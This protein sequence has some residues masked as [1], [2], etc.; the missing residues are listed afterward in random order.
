MS[1]LHMNIG[2][3]SALG[4]WGQLPA[5]AWALP[6][7]PGPHG[8]PC[9]A[10]HRE[11]PLSAKRQWRRHPPP[12]R[13][14]PPRCQSSRQA[15]QPGRF[16][17]GPLGGRPIRGRGHWTLRFE[18]ELNRFGH[19]PSNY[20]HVHSLLGTLASFPGQRDRTNGLG[21]LRMLNEF[22][23]RRGLAQYLA[24]ISAP[25]AMLL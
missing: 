20:R 7:S 5:M 9:P 24:Q 8:A 6:A 3:W 10:V 14:Q 23:T 21:T 15:S 25:L 12:G 13:P 4:L 19:E 1:C 18:F 11:R 16:A 17:R 2:P 22:L